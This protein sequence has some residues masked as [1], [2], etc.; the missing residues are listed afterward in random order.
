MLTPYLGLEG[1]DILG[2]Y[3]IAAAANSG[4][5]LQMVTSDATPLTPSPYGRQSGTL[6]P[7]TVT[8]ASGKKETG[9]LLQPVTPTGPSVF[10]VLA[11]IYDESVAVGQVAAV[12]ASRQGTQ[13]ATDQYVAAGGSAAGQI[14][15]DGTV[16]LDELCGIYQGQPR[17]LQTGDLARLQFKGQVIQRNTPLAIFEII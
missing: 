9:W 3:K 6:G 10:S 4:L 11:S 12:V 1:R 7:A 14:V 5:A 17:V 13:I 2:V 8:T 16:A 15:F